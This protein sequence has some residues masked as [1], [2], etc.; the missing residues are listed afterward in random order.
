MQ[1]ADPLRDWRLIRDAKLCCRYVRQKERELHQ[2]EA[3]LEEHKDRIKVMQEHL[4]NVQVGFVNA[5][6]RIKCF[7]LALDGVLRSS[8]V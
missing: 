3:A 5:H 8:S 2:C 4:R 1:N 6:L 7:L